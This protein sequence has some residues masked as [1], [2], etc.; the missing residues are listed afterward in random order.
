MRKAKKEQIKSIIA[1]QKQI[2]MVLAEKMH[3]ENP[4]NEQNEW[5]DKIF[6]IL[7]ECQEAAIAIGTS[8]EKTE[9]DSK[10]IIT[11]LE[12]YCESLYQFS[13]EMTKV[14]ADKMQDALRKVEKV[15]ETISEKTIACFLP[16]K[17]SMWDSLESVKESGKQKK[18][19]HN[20]VQNILTSR[21]L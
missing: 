7:Q 18:L 10:E 4:V 17:A 14:Y 8:I 19:K 20:K 16:Y 2:L 12:Q 5:Q 3:I 11:V 21:M 6:D 1:L 9:K 15:I 13:M